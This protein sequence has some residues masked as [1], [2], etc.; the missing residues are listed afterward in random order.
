MISLTVDYVPY[1]GRGAQ[2]LPLLLGHLTISIRAILLFCSNAFVSF[3]LTQR[4]FRCSSL[5]RLSQISITT[6][7]VVCR[8][9]PAFVP[10]RTERV[11]SC[12]AATSRFIEQL[13]W[14]F[15]TSGPPSQEHHHRNI[16]CHHRSSSTAHPR[17]HRPASYHTFGMA[18]DDRERRVVK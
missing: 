5:T 9:Q 10:W 4:R 12:A 2:I 6:R 1:R 8:L 13:S 7:D 17:Q 15:V 14:V 11:N 18:D 16:E 3:S